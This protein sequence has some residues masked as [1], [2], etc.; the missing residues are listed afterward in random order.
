MA[1]LPCELSASEIKSLSTQS[2]CLHLD[3]LNLITMGK[4]AQLV[5]RLKTHYHCSSDSG[6]DGT[7]SDA[8]SSEAVN[9]RS[10]SS[11]AVRDKSA[12]S[13]A[14]SDKS[15]SSEDGSDHSTP[16]PSGDDPSSD[17]LDDRVRDDFPYMELPSKRRRTS[18]ASEPHSHSRSRTWS[19]GHRCRH[20]KGDGCHKEGRCS[21]RAHSS[22]SSSGDSRHLVH[23]APPVV[24]RMIALFTTA[25]ASTIVTTIH[26]PVPVVFPAP[27][28]IQA[29]VDITNTEISATDCT[30]RTEPWS[31]VHS[32]S[33]ATLDGG[34]GEVSMSILTGF[35][36]PQA[37]PSSHLPAATASDAESRSPGYM[38]GVEPLSVC[39][40]GP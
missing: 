39:P 35:S 38:D 25:A 33:H 10:A 14:A 7:E 34:L 6:T 2:L 26:H 29:V 13:E 8:P 28:V 12:S 9:G 3:Q 21:C 30:N 27:V 5:A 36:L 4:Q 32:S 23:P 22:N 17:E 24:A 37:H 31:A 18:H 15:S 40:T 16:Q 19:Q 20:Q 11:K 1:I